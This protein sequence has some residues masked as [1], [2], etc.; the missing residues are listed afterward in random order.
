MMMDDE[1]C[2]ASLTEAV[3]TPQDGVFTAALPH[4]D[5]ATHSYSL[6][7]VVRYSRRPVLPATRNKVSRDQTSVRAVSGNWSFLCDE[8]PHAADATCQSHLPDLF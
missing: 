7:V 5:K 2:A 3:I 1:S 6:L 4:T 8:S